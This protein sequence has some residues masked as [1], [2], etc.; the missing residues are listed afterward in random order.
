M[1]ANGKYPLGVTKLEAKTK[2]DPDINIRKA[3]TKLIKFEQKIRGKDGNKRK[4]HN[5]VEKDEELDGENVKSKKQKVINNIKNLRNNEQ[6]SSEEKNNNEDFNN[7]K[8]K[9]K[10]KHKKK[11]RIPETI[12]ETI[13]NDQ[14]IQDSSILSEE[15]QLHNIVENNSKKRSKKVVVDSTKQLG[16]IKK[17][18]NK[19]I[20]CRKQKNVTNNIECVFERNS[21]TWVV[22]NVSKEPEETLVP[23]QIGKLLYT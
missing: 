11:E 18:E 23:N 20:K 17:I 21:G 5:S 13:S 7:V 14:N 4:R 9:Q 19:T 6:I 12:E 8:D 16:K 10:K 3:T 1:M 22:F 15:I 2:N